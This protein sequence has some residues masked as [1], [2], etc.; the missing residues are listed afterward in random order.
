MVPFSRS[1]RK[2]RLIRTGTWREV[3]SGGWGIQPRPPSSLAK[4]SLRCKQLCSRAQSNNPRPV[5]LQLVELVRVTAVAV[6]LVAT[7]C[8]GGGGSQL[9]SPAPS[10]AFSGINIDYAAEGR[11]S[12]DNWS[13]TTPVAC[14]P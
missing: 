13:T 8:G 11:C 3:R 2:F 6:I 7:G 12:D 9:S 1:G 10:P 5:G 14:D 4:E